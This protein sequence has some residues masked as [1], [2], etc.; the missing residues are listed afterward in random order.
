MPKSIRQQ[1]TFRAPARVIYDTLMTSRSH[2]AVTGSPARIS[3][4]VGGR[5]SC[6]DGYITGYNLHLRPNRRIVQ[7]WRGSDWDEGDF[8]VA[9]FLLTPLPG[10][11]TRL[12]FRQS[13]VPDA[14]AASIRQGWID[15]YW[16][17][18]KEALK[19]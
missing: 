7:A 14:F 8:S 5:V 6:Y 18:M 19:G 15:Y 4:K 17:P 10:G 2:A 3:R 13:G 11:R 9:D 16:N 12:L 1:V